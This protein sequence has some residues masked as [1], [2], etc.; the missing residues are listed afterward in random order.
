[1]NATDLTQN[2]EG[3]HAGLWQNGNINAAARSKLLKIAVEFFTQLNLPDAAIEDITFT[4]SLAN[5]NWTKFS[6]V[7]LHLIVNFDLI[8]A[9][10]DIVREYFSAKTSN[11]NRIHKIK[12]F[13]HEVELYVQ[14]KEEPH[15][16]SG[17][18]SLKF[19]KWLA[20]PQ[21][22]SISVSADALEKKAKLFIDMMERADDL[23]ISKDY[24]GAYEFSK[25]LFD[26]IKNFRKA[27]L[28]AGGEYS[29][30]NLVFKYLRNNEYIKFLIDLRNNS[31]DK[32]LSLNGD[33]EKKFKIFVVKDETKNEG[34][35]KINEIEKF[36]KRI[37]NK[38]ER[39]K[40]FAEGR[41]LKIAQFS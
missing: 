12:I 16:S 1:M 6:D 19:N 17:V 34:F 15:H 2:K 41:G 27:G 30:E 10:T 7:D 9:N 3:L 33:Y 14:N 5:F 25:K 20:K 24:K 22:K 35:D 38:Q 32:M 37:A 39:Y 11:W 4:G 26:K 13:N 36:R 29:L 40:R 23:L 28:E 18:Y 31:Y 8:D 21:Q